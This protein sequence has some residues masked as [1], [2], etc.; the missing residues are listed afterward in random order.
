L[1]AVLQADVNAEMQGGH[2]AL[3]MAILNPV[4]DGT[5]MARLLLSRGA[6]HEVVV[7][8]VG[9]SN[10]NVVVQYWLDQVA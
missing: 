10:L 5:E 7:V 9:I 1:S 6:S 8:A 4:H 3:K 2:T